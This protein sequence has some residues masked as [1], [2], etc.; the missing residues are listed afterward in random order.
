LLGCSNSGIEKQ[1]QT[2]LGTFVEIKIADRGITR[3]QKL[4]ALQAAF[5]R[6]SKIEELMSLYLPKSDV[7]RLNSSAGK[8]RVRVDD[9]TAEVIQKAIDFSAQTDGAFDITMS[10]FGWKKITVNSGD[11]T[12]FFKESD[13]DIDLGAIAKGFAVDKAIEA[14]RQS[15]IENAL[16][17]AGGD[18]YCMGNGTDGKGWKIGVQHP[19]A[20]NKILFTLRLKNKAIATSGDYQRFT[21][22]EGRRISHIVDPR[23]GRVVSDIPASV[24]IIAPD[25][26]TADALA[27][28]IFVLGAKEGMRLIQG[29]DG[30]EVI[31]ANAGEGG[32]LD[33]IASDGA[34]KMLR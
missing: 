24:T 2:A 28:A 13:M 22:I 8:N 1:T 9:L 17:N 20:K 32:K 29:L 26:T 3:P 25:C 19:R 30:I 23:S 27:T 18:M 10:P 16:I 15:N 34:R 33:I 6:I 4:A 12:I 7:G 14:L 31:I 21:M 11:K 5:K